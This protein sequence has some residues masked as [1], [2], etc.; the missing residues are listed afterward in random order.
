M[1]L[2]RG[3]QESLLYMIWRRKS[4][5]W[6]KQML[7][8]KDFAKMCDNYANMAKDLR[9]FLSTFCLKRRSGYR[10]LRKT[11]LLLKRDIYAAGGA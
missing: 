2:T 4:S 8:H 3:A 9:H 5:F 10:V 6:R 11:V 1:Q 7:D